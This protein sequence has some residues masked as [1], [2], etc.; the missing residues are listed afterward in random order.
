MLVVLCNVRTHTDGLA[1]DASQLVLS[2]LGQCE[3]TLTLV[4]WRSIHS[5]LFVQRE[6]VSHHV[7]AHSTSQQRG[8]PERKTNQINQQAKMF[9]AQLKYQF[10]HLTL[11]VHHLFYKYTKIQGV[12]LSN[13]FPHKLTLSWILP[14]RTFLI[15]FVHFV[16]LKL[17][18]F[19][20][21]KVS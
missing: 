3:K 1:H 17:V 2:I 7:A 8:E 12:H 14:N 6:I 13:T 9:V 10:L 11:W 5:F 16:F 15:T 20:F 18:S 19:S 4:I 21:Y